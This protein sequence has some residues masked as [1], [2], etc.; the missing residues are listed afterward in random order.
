V[1][2]T[3]E[4]TGLAREAYPPLVS[5]RPKYL[6]WRGQL[7]SSDAPRCSAANDGLRCST[8]REAWA[9]F[10]KVR[11]DHGGAVSK[12]R[13]STASEVVMDDPREAAHVPAA[14]KVQACGLLVQETPDRS[15]NWTRS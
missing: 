15:S 8:R 7:A 9:R 4:S 1:S 14:E 3:R 11:R 10:D 12:L 5:G 2:T 13:S 6:Q